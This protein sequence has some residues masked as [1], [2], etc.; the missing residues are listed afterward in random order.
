VSVFVV[1]TTDDWFGLLELGTAHSIKWATIIYC[2]SLLFI[3]NYVVF[4]LLMAIILDT[5]AESLVEAEHDVFKDSEESDVEDEDHLEN[6][7]L[8]DGLATN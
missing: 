5:F 3:I 8:E 2:F 4:G 7:I 6:T 1:S